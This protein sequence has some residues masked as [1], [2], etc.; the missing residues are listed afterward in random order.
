MAT[1][2]LALL[3][4]LQSAYG[5]SGGGFTADLIPRDHP[6]SPFHPNRVRSAARRSISRA[7]RLWARHG[8]KDF[9]SDVTYSNGEYYMK[10][11]I[12]SPPLETF[13]LIDTG[14]DLLWTQCEPCVKCYRQK[15]P[16]FNPRNSS[17]Y[18]TVQCGTR[19]CKSLTGA[20]CGGHDGRK[21]NYFY[22]YFDKSSTKGVLAM[23]TFRIG[24]TP[25]K[26]I[27]LPRTVF[28]CSYNTSKGFDSSGSGIIGLGGR[29][30]LSF[31]SRIED[32]IGGQFGY[33]LV[34]ESRKGMSKISFGE[35]SVVSGPGA[36]STP[37]VSTGSD[38][39]YLVNLE[40][41]S[42]GKTSFSYGDNSTNSE[43]KESSKG[44]IMVI[45]SG[46]PL[47]FVPSRF[48]DHLESA[49]TAAIA[50]PRVP[51]PRGDLDLC[52]RSPGGKLDAPAVTLHF[53]GGADM[54]LNTGS[55]FLH[56]AE[57]LVC[58]PISPNDQV[59]ILGNFAQMGFK[60]RFD[61]RN[62]TVSFM[63]ATK[64]TVQ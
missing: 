57:D 13:L 37:L 29:G 47:T 1:L 36:F 30:P 7:H 27:T 22:K 35:D 16:I 11:S 21:C 31:I 33:C 32:S 3:F 64:C 6:A 50:L 5:G 20:R 34:P 55:T 60:F 41:F 25:G 63:A 42:V 14:S 40:G 61:L 8:S 17:T 52:Y 38:Q 59:P 26:T 56:L 49:I 23:E 15:S 46:T 62:S 45:D 51:D 9:E 39:L 43:A 53:A 58:V 4:L 28:G 24:T 10:A 54:V 44:V 18:K 2:F 48:F 12:G 19:L